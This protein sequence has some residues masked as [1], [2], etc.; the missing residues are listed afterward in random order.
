MKKG[1]ILIPAFALVALFAGGTASAHG[2]FGGG[3]FGFGF[4]LDADTRV[5]MFEEQMVK[6]STLLGITV[7]DMKA[8]WAEGKSVAEIAKEK[9]ISEADL[10]ARRQAQQEAEMKTWLQLLVTKGQITQAQAD[11]RLTFWKEHAEKR[12][13]N[14]QKK[15]QNRL[16]KNKHS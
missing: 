16:E 3:S 6:Q 12:V 11:A 2:G 13:L 15:V 9:N 7:S 10:R 14:M 5:K 8:A 1:Y 4:G